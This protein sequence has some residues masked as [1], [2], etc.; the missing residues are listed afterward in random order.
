[1]RAH[2]RTRPARSAAMMEGGGEFMKSNMVVPLLY[3]S[4]S[5]MI[6]ESGPAQFGSQP[7]PVA[8]TGGNYMHNFYLPPSGSSTPWWPSWSPDGKWIAFAMDGSI[9]KVGLG[10][11]VAQEMVYA[12]EYLSSPEWSP[13]GK[14]LVYT[15]DDGKDHKSE[16]TESRERPIRAPDRGEPPQSRSGLVTGWHPAGVCLHGAERLLQH[17]RHG[18][19]ERQEGKCSRP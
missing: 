14:W 12:K 13:D 10:E 16:D 7:H 6:F 19:E 5:C 9:W 18:S 2:D 8:R 17:L 11:T 15:S 4:L 3:L 1:M